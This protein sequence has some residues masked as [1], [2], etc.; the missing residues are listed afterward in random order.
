VVFPDEPA[1]GLDPEARLRVW[2]YFETTDDRV[3]DDAVPRSGRPP[4]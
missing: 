1:T 3:P 4:L 2:E